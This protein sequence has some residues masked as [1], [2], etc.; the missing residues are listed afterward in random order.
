MSLY[1]DTD[2]AEQAA[3]RRKVSQAAHQGQRPSA[4]WSATQL[5]EA[6]AGH[7]DDLVRLEQVAA[8]AWQAQRERDRLSAHRRDVAY[9]AERLL[10]RWAEDERRE[11]RERAWAEA[12]RLV[13]EREAES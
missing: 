3:A 9:E 10:K 13:T 2:H 8:Q 12:E 7:E 11:R 6:F 1:P 5:A 4:Y